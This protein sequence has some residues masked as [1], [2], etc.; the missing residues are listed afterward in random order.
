MSRDTAYLVV[1][2]IGAPHGVR[3]WVKVHSYTEPVDN[4]FDYDPWYLGS[5]NRSTEWREAPVLEA[6]EHGKGIIAHFKG[7]DDRDAAAELRGQEIAIRRDQLPPAAE[8]E[9][10]WV[11]LVG[12]KVETLDGVDLGTVDHLM[13][14]GA[15]DVLVVK[16][17][18]QR[19]IPFVLEHIVKEVDIKGG[20]MR[21]DWDPDFE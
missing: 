21:V 9:Y 15:N 19:L 5:A 13:A 14:T 17:E 20:V 16:G 1:G 3:G 6:R 7:Y 18:R 8:G 4:L 10:Y 11:D 12:L 2:K